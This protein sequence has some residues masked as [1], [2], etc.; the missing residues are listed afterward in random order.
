LHYVEGGLDSRKVH[1]L[2]SLDHRKCPPNYQF[3]SPRH[4]SSSCR[5]KHASRRLEDGS[6]S[7][8][9][10]LLPNPR[11][12]CCRLVGTRQQALSCTD[13]GRPSLPSRTTVFSLER[14]RISLS[15]ARP[16]KVRPRRGQ[17]SRVWVARQHG[18]IKVSIE[19]LHPCPLRWTSLSHPAG[20]LWSPRQ[21]RR[22]G[23]VVCRDVGS[24]VSIVGDD[25]EPRPA[26][27]K[28]RH[29]PALTDNDSKKT[30]AVEVSEA[31]TLIQLVA[32][33]VAEGA[34]VEQPVGG[35]S[36]AEL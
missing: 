32:C 9:E 19:C 28:C 5:A 11:R 29:V 4:S 14:G 35:R 24:C 13:Y 36:H 25:R 15:A 22:P 10:I 33:A 30:F 34:A 8:L 16:G 6:S 17:V 27:G 7:D 23:H 3:V 31:A 1:F 20:K 18:T 12:D 26:R 2:L 21:I